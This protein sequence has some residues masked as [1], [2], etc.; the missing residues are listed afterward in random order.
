KHPKSPSILVLASKVY[1]ELGQPAKSEAFLTVALAADPSNPATYA[2]LAEL[3]ISQKRLDDAKKQ[4]AQ[5]VKLKPRSVAATT[6]MGLISS[7]QG[8]RDGAQQW[9]E[10]RLQMRRYAAAAAN[11]LAW[12]YAEG[13]GNLEVA[14]HLAM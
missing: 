14:L 11:N 5:F 12:L 9:G 6:M 1:R 2:L 10:K 3:Y 13:R 8:N 7:V 4:F